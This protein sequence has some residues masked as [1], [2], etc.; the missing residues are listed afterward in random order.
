[1]ER[2]Q[3]VNVVSEK[4]KDVGKWD[5][6]TMAM[7]AQS[8]AETIPSYI[9]MLFGGEQVDGFVNRFQDVAPG[10][11]IYDVGSGPRAILLRPQTATATATAEQVPGIP[12]IRARG[13]HR[14]VGSPQQ[15]HASA[16]RFLPLQWRGVLPVRQMHN[17]NQACQRLTPT[18]SHFAKA[19]HN[20][21]LELML[22]A[23]AADT[24]KGRDVWESW[25]EVG[26]VIHL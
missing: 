12:V 17:L 5:A 9:S 21:C 3:I 16:P 26:S 10:F 24:A 11:I 4:L 6:A 25:A 2:L 22:N 15:A 13:D 1:V 8:Y 23:V 7:E 14:H 20:G 19:E 18:R